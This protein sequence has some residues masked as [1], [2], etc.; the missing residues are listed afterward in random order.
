MKIP[1]ALI[2]DNNLLEQWQQE[3]LDLVDD[4][5]EIKLILNCKN[6]HNKKKLFKHFIY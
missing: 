2:I 4:L 3:S 1:V 5:I 6:T